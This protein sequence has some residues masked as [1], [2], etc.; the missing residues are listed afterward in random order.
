MFCN[1][2]YYFDGVFWSGS[3][4]TQELNTYTISAISEKFKKFFNSSKGKKLYEKIIEG[5]RYFDR[6][7]VFEINFNELSDELKKVISQSKK[8]QIQEGVH[9]AYYEMLLQL[10]GDGVIKLDKEKQFK[11]KF[12]NLDGFDEVYDNP[13]DSNREKELDL[14][15]EFDI[16][17]EIRL[18]RKV[19]RSSTVE[20]EEKQKARNR[21][22]ELKDVLGEQRDPRLSLVD[23]K[24][25]FDCWKIMSLKSGKGVKKQKEDAKIRIDELR[26]ELGQDPYFG[27]EEF[28]GSW[29]GY[30][31]LVMKEG[32]FWTLDDT[33]EIL[34]YEKGKYYDGGVKI[35]KKILLELEP[36]L[37]IKYVNEIIARI[38]TS[39]WIP[40]KEFDKY[41]DEFCFENKIINI[42]TG[43]ISNHNYKKLFRIQLPIKYDEN[44]KCPK[45]IKFM[46]QCLPNPYDYIVV[47]EEFAS[48]LLKNTISFQE[49]Y[50]HTGNGDN[51][52]SL[53]FHI[54]EWFLGE[55]LYSSETFHKLIKDRFAPANLENKL[56]N[57]YADIVSDAIENINA[58]KPIVSGDTINAEFKHKTAHPFKNFSKMFFSANELPVI[59]EKTF[60]A[61][62]RIMLTK[63]E[64]KFLKKEEYEKEL[65][66]IKT[67]YSELDSE[68]LNKELAKSGVHLMNKQFLKTI[69][70]EENEKQ[71]ILNML[72]ILCKNM[73]R[74]DGFFHKQDMEQLKDMW[75]E[76]STAIEKYVNEC[77]ITDPN[78]FIVKGNF[79]T[80]YVKYSIEI[81]G[82]PPRADNVFHKQVKKILKVE[83]GFKRI[84]GVNER[85]YL[86]I[87]W[88]FDNSF[89][90]KYKRNT[91]KMISKDK[92]S[93]QN[94]E[95]LI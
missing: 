43:E 95:K 85:V 21:I 22:D 23:E 2:R 81:T 60:S 9:R 68:Q 15:N 6:E 4:I 62:K 75:S 58:M 25:F 94:N 89:I 84:H 83:E 70:D 77:V 47:M 56:A 52:K 66:N 73:I 41:P 55:G 14:D 13:I 46:Q 69:T 18:Q 26:K 31:K 3:K 74:R 92:K 37:D 79:H 63:W 34:Y 20:F 30:A 80:L 76:N 51:G 16:R 93:N 12:L 35:I 32:H 19:I 33:D 86:G 78:D 48:C 45:F 5:R 91:K 49:M 29:Y 59:E 61:L 1:F 28:D 17:R 10:Y 27:D 40:R 57:I 50:F 53:F 44:A 82:K 64:Q 7:Y 90:K 87:S 42:K 54:I 11:H 71:G 88:N 65:E 39:T 36:D 8:I 72:L 67:I 24:E 38:K